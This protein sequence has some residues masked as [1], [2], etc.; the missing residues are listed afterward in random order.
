MERELRFSLLDPPPADEVLEDAMRGSAYRLEAGGTRQQRDVYV[1]TAEFA[2]RAAGVALRRREVDGRRLATLKSVASGHGPAFEREE[3]ELPL[4]EHGAWPAELLE[5][6]AQLTPVEPRRLVAQVEVRTE[7]RV[8]VLRKG[9]VKVAELCFDEVSARYPGAEREALF[10]EAEIEAA[11]GVELS[12]LEK[13]AERL[14]RAVTLT[15]AGASK[16]QRAEALLAL[17]AA[18]G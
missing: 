17:G 10:R 5:R 4:G 6:L 1:D 8:F 3:L 2:L 15:P 13:V 7:R 11:D 12:E 18:L 14:E 9:D 16:L